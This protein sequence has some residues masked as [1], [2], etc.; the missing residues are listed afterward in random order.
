MS[1]HSKVEQVVG[2]CKGQDLLVDLSL[3]KVPQGICIGVVGLCCFDCPVG[4]FAV[5]SSALFVPLAF[6][7]LHLI[8]CIFPL[9]H[10]L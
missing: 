1:V 7:G 10:T 4:S 5:A 9:L 3:T 8:L 6:C 2:L